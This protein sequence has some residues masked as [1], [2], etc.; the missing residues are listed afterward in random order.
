MHHSPQSKK[1]T[2]NIFTI[3]LPS[4]GGKVENKISSKNGKCFLIKKGIHK[5]QRRNK[6]FL[7]QTKAEKVHYH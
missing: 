1:Y 2:I 7:K 3:S 6:D 4:V 5:K